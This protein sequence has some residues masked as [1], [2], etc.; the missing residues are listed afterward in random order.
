MS[1]N[2]DLRAAL[3]AL[4]EA[5]ERI[6]WLETELRQV[7]PIRIRYPDL[8]KRQEMIVQELHGARGAYVRRERLLRAVWPCEDL[9]DPKS[10]DVMVHRIR[11]RLGNRVNIV[12]KWGV[13]YAIPL[14]DV[15]Q[16]R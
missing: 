11:R 15:H 3:D 5:R 1:H 2:M 9:G 6:R 16:E 7:A 10:V 13:G 12:A 14:D 4:D 8:T